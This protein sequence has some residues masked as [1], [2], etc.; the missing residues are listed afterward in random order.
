[1]SGVTERKATQTKFEVFRVDALRCLSVPVV[2]RCWRRFAAF[3][4]TR[5]PFLYVPL[6]VLTV[7][8]A[9]GVRVSPSSL[10]GLVQ[11]RPRQVL[12]LPQLPPVEEQDT[13]GGG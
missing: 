7:C 11:T 3:C 4:L 2:Q 1:M 9:G 12:Q 10:R 8:T 6:L 13:S 5:L